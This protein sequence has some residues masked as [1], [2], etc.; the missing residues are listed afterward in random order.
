MK[1]LVK[2]IKSNPNCTAIIDNDCWW[3]VDTEGND[4]AS[5]DDVLVE[6]CDCYGG[7][8]LLALAEIVGINIDSV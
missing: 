4:I 6:F 1:D 7:A 8:I 3:L 2:I 5:S